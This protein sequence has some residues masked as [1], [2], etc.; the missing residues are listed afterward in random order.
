[1]VSKQRLDNEIAV[2]QAALLRLA[3]DISVAVSI[4]GAS[5]T[6]FRPSDI[7]AQIDLRITS[8]ESTPG[9]GGYADY[10]IGGRGTFTYF[11]VVGGLSVDAVPE[12][13]E[14]TLA[15]AEH[16]IAYPGYTDRYVLIWRLSSE[17][18]LTSI[19]LD[20]DPTNENQIGGWTKYNTTVR[21]AGRDGNV[22]VSDHL[23]THVSDT[24]RL[25]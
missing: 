21:N 18:D 12:E 6:Y 24:L 2:L 15:S 10:L 11:T 25:A 14:L 22:W 19:I 13:A 9:F 23:L 17:P 16:R 5:I 1:M 3:T 20:S 7:Q 4:D 8:L